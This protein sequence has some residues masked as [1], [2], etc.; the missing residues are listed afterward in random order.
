MNNLTRITVTI[1]PIA[2][3]I[4]AFEAGLSL[5]TPATTQSQVQ[6]VTLGPQA[7]PLI[8]HFPNIRSASMSTWIWLGSEHEQASY[9]FLDAISNLT[10]LEHVK[11]YRHMNNREFECM[12]SARIFDA[13]H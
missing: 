11:V 3:Y 13:K 5:A 12:F 7:H 4:E 2:P 8:R 1:P 9:S 6:T 10:N